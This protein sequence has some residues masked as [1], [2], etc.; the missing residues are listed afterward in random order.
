MRSFAAPPKRAPH[1]P[2]SVHRVVSSTGRGLDPVLKDKFEARLGHNFADI[3]VHADA[4]AAESADA[5]HA[6]A[7]TVGPHIV[8]GAGHYSP[9]TAAGQR[10]LAHELI[11]TVQQSG[12][13]L[14]ADLPLTTSQDEAEREAATQSAAFVRGDPVRIGVRT[15][16]C[17]ARDEEGGVTVEEE[18]EPAATDGDIVLPDKKDPVNRIVINLT[19]N[20]VVFYTASG[21]K[22]SG[23]AWT[24]LEPGVYTGVK[25]DKKKR[26]WWIPH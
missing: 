25:A 14:R 7:Y 24:D 8:F 10:L 5:I 12:Q 15:G 3:R 13:G 26:K 6:A 23:S 17:V 9:A 4:R 21:L 20:K 22:L 1:A 2:S 19:S 18:S 16:Q 11:H